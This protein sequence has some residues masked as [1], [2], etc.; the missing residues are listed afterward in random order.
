MWHTSSVTTR[1]VTAPLTLLV[2][3]QMPLW[4]E[5][6]LPTAGGIFLFY[7]AYG[8]FKTWRESSGHGIALM[9]G[10][11]GTMIFGSAGIILLSAGARNFGPSLN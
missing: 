7:F 10:F 11:Y 1:I 8:T 6:A 3:S 2:L 9:L 5:Q 4:L